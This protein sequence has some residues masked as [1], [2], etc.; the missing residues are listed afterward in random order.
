MSKG[1]GNSGS[2][3]S[4]KS[5]H[6][7]PNADDGWK[8]KAAGGE[9]ASSTHETKAQAVERARELAKNQDKSQVVVHRRDGT[10]Q[11]EWTY[12]SDPFP[13]EG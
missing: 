2:S 7:T 6:V 1:K 13:P 4:R 5:Y 12:G 3:G 9:R 10:I 11:T 8:V